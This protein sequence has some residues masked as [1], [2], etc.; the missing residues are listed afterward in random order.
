MRYFALLMRHF[1]NHFWLAFV[2][3]LATFHYEIRWTIIAKSSSSSSKTTAA[4]SAAISAST[5]S[6]SAPSTH[7]SW[8]SHFMLLITLRVVRPW[9]ILQFRRVVYC[10]VSNWL[11][12]LMLGSCLM[13]AMRRAYFLSTGLSSS[14]PSIHFFS[15]FARAVVSN[16]KY[17]H[18]QQTV[19]VLARLAAYRR[20]PTPSPIPRTNR[21]TKQPS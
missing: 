11:V 16:P 3:K 8:C 10:L 1:A 14:W 7:W 9:C 12:L 21:L 13:S 5:A 17:I 20:W 4:T 15:G 19:L 18:P 6:S 2:H